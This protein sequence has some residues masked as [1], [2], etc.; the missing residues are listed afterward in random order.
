MDKRPTVREELY[1]KMMKAA[2]DR[3]MT[4]KQWLEEKIKIGLIEDSE[5][6]KHEGLPVELDG[7]PFTVKQ[8]GSN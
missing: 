3:Q 4:V 5:L 6:V 7:L 8:E 1:Y 2:A